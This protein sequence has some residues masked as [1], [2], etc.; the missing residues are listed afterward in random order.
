MVTIIMASVKIVTVIKAN[1]IMVSVTMVN[2]IMVS[3]IMVSAIILNVIILVVMAS[4]LPLPN[5]C[6]KK[7]YNTGPLTNRKTL[8]IDLNPRERYRKSSGRRQ[9]QSM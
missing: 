7:F 4:I 5:D 9:R 6:G 2:V 1:D 8:R 3:V